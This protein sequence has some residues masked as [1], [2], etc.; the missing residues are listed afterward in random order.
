MLYGV[1]LAVVGCRECENHNQVVL[2]PSVTDRNQMH[3]YKWIEIAVTGY[4]Q[5]FVL[6][7]SGTGSYVRHHYNLINCAC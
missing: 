1:Y 7:H 3:P 5:C 6:A 4:T 2:E